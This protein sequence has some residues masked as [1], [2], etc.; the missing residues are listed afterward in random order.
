MRKRIFRIEMNSFS[1]CLRIK[2]QSINSRFQCPDGDAP[3][4]RASI[5]AMRNE[6]EILLRIIYKKHKLKEAVK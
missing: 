3:E 1:G 5:N 4:L 6:D 2:D